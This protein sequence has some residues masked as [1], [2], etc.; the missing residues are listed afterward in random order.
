MGVIKHF[1]NLL[2]NKR[3]PLYVVLTLSVL[4]VYGLN[5]TITN[6]HTDGPQKEPVADNKCINP[7]NVV[8]QGGYKLTRPLLLVD[9]KSDDKKFDGIK[10]TVS[11]YIDSFVKTS[12]INEAS[13]YYYSFNENIQFNINP[14][15]KYQAS[16]LVEITKIIAL[17]KQE[18]K[19]PGVLSQK[20]ASSNSTL[21][22]LIL[23][24][25]AS[26]EKNATHVL[27]PYIDATV[28][29]DVYASI[30]EPFS[31]A[32]D[33]KATISVAQFTKVIKILYNVG[34]L[35]E[36]S[37]KTVMELISN[38]I[39]FDGMT[40]HIGKEIS[41]A[42]YF[43]D[44]DFAVNHELHELGIFYVK[45]N[46]YMLCVMAKGKDKK[47]L[48]TLISNISKTIFDNFNKPS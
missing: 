1:S 41:V 29:K 8:R 2:F 38:T 45:N 7:L 5:Y 16:D 32:S 14:N 11:D 48:S 36:S 37:C 34:Y 31:I 23:E 17:M 3:V 43:S 30:Q 22:K 27:D 19:N 13:V 9:T 33:P 28:L 44:N 6:C 18:E 15:Q 39:N 4:A 24:A 35:K 46:P 20:V 21:R 42:H 26:S 47:N 40:K 25:I 10:K 12:V